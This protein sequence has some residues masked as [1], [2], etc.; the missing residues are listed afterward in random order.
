MGGSAVEHSMSNRRGADDEQSRE[1][2]IDEV[3]SRYDEMGKE[4]RGDGENTVGRLEVVIPGIY[5]LA[6]A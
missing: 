1:L 6:L 3:L 5:L 4:Y 2:D